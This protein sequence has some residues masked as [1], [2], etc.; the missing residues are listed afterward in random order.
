MIELTDLQRQELQT[1]MTTA[2]DPVTKRTYVLLPA[3]LYEQMRAA[4][5]EDIDVRTVGLLV[6]RAMQDDDANDPYLESY[7]KYLP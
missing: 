5:E 4:L 3:E 2:I 6:E 7:Q 1:P